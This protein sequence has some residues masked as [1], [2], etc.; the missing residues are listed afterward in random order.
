MMGDGA[1]KDEEVIEGEFVEAAGADD[2]PAARRRRLW[3]R[4]PWALVLLL[5]VFIAGLFAA[6]AVERQLRS[7]GLLAPAEAAAPPAGQELQSALDQL[8]ARLDALD[9]RLRVVETGLEGVSAEASAL[10]LA[11]T[12]L[13]QRLSAREAAPAGDGSD[14]RSALDALAA[15]VDALEA[16]LAGLAAA[17][18]GGDAELAA[19]VAALEDRI[20]AL[21][22]SPAHAPATGLARHLL[23]LDAAIESG[24][25]FADTLTALE[26]AIAKLPADM[27]LRMQA[28]LESLRPYAATGVASLSSLK[29]RFDGIAGAVI[30]AAPPP[31]EA[32]WW[33]RIKDRLA[34]L[35]VI[36]R[37]GAIEGTGIAA[38][39]ARAE[40]ALE[41]DDLAAAVAAFDGLDAATRA[42]ADAWLEAARRHLAAAAALERLIAAGTAPRAANDGRAPR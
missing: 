36:R 22:A 42:P 40:A 11:Q 41:R 8:R 24:R 15:R 30:R 4:L 27:R 31:P 32:G 5:A 19:R 6:P 21:D 7:L 29:A 25:P 38:R 39:M 23:A 18:P 20:A 26:A 28:P 14:I 37:K 13:A 1:D 12:T 10:R 33:A 2:V 16:R 9:G 17:P 34:G 35:V 3:R